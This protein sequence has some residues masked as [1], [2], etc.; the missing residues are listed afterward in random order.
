MHRA[1]AKA[2]SAKVELMSVGSIDRARRALAANR[3]DIAVLDVALALGSGSTLLHEL[4]CG[5]GD[6]IPLILFSP[7]GTLPNM[8]RSSETICSNR[9]RRST[10]SSPS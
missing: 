4:R 10:V 5:E 9:A 6:T 2:L 3:F 1:I 7:R 8:A